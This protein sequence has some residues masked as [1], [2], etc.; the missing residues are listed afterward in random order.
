[1]KH[2]KICNCQ[3]FIEANAVWIECKSWT[4][5]PLLISGKT[6]KEKGE[7]VEEWQIQI[8]LFVQFLG[9]FFSKMSKARLDAVVIALKSS[10]I[11]GSVLR[12]A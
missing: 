2:V 4:A 1:M 11:P 6:K 12:C 3:Q 7:T 9:S 10:S 8:I 5:G